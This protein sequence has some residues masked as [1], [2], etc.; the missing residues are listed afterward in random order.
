MTQATDYIEVKL[1]A[2]ADYVS[3]A[4]LTVS[5]IANRMG[6]G[7][8]D[9]ED[10]KVA[11]AEACTNVVDHA[12]EQGGS[13]VLGCHV[14][15]DA[16]EVSVTDEG[17]HFDMERLAEEKGPVSGTKPVAEL[18]EGGLGLFLIDTLMDEV[19]IRGETG[20]AIVMRKFFQ[21]DGVEEN[22][23]AAGPINKQEQ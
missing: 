7:Y 2:K 9:I 10:M 19:E 22:V 8:D 4:R 11:V 18:K 13:M 12:Y 1:P 6:W 15:S 14:R 5:G 23:D 20:V 21:R 17:Q 16:I 3:I